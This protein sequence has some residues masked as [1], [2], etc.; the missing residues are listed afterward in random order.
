LLAA[1]AMPT[2]AAPCFA[3][4]PSPVT[5]CQQFDFGTACRTFQPPPPAPPGNRVLPDGSKFLDDS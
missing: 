1:V 5:I 3:Q 4:Q 2:I